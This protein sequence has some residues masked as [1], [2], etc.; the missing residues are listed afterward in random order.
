[1]ALAESP[2][3]D[4]RR[5]FEDFV[6]GME[7]EYGTVAVDAEEIVAFARKYDPQEF[8][9]DPVRAAQGEFGGLIASGWHTAS[10]MMR[11]LVDRYLSNVASLGSPGVDE[12]RWLAPVRP[13]NRLS[14]RVTVL[15]ARRSRSKP[16]CGLVRSFIEVL[17]EAGTVVMTVKGMTLMRCRDAG[18][19]PARSAPDP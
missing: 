5:Y 17:N 13:G 11:L 15:D 4:E 3:H 7:A 18:N 10:L 2:A 8:H 9:T 14:I 12:L 16:H 19:Q 6:P 1:M